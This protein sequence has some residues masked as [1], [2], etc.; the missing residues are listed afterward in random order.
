MTQNFSLSA[1]FGAL[2]LMLGLQHTAAAQCAAGET[3][4]MV[5][6][7]TDNYPGE[8]TWT[9][10]DANGTLLSGGP[11][12]TQGTTYTD[13]VCIDGAVEFPC[14]QFVINDSY[15]D[16]ICCGY[17]NGAYTLYMDGA[18]VATGGNYGQQ[19]IVQFDC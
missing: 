8:I 7:L 5:E 18:A 4:V 3:E 15:G 19:D 17:G 12:S 10:S 16:G 6:I 9:L 11:Y 14:L 1:A 2:A 13:V